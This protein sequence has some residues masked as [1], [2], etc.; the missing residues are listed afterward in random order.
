MEATKK[1]NTTVPAILTISS[2]I[3]AVGLYVYGHYYPQRLLEGGSL[4]FVFIWIM[5]GCSALVAIVSSYLLI[6]RGKG[7]RAARKY[8]YA[9]I[10]VFIILLAY[11]SYGFEQQAKLYSKIEVN[12]VTRQ[13]IM[14]VPA[15]YSPDRPMPL[16]IALHGGIGNA[17]QFMQE[18]GFNSLADQY[19]FIVVYP[20]G[21]GTFRYS[22][23]IWNSGTIEA[24]LQ[25]G[26][27]DVAFIEQLLAHIESTYAVN[28][29][30]IYIV[31]HS[32]GAMMS[33]RMAGE[34]ASAF[35]AVASVAGTIGGKPLPNASLYEIPTPS[36]PV[37][38]IE[39]H[40]LLDTNVRYN[41]GSPTSGLEV[42]ERWDISVNDTIG[43][44]V[45]YDHCNKTKTEVNSTNSLIS[46]DT[47]SGGLNSTQVKLFTFTTEGHFWQDLNKATEETYGISLSQ[48]I[49]SSLA[50]YSK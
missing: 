35:A 49:W 2:S 48:L 8:V 37:S 12:G 16:L 36:T 34:D 38:V 9:L 43:F 20:D 17:Y 22:D 46:E 44:W 33:Y 32:N 24:P 11:E 26:Y 23:H 42:G 40:G 47:Y 41:G 29:S 25:K 28:A 27:Q 50:K 19:G 15:N 10:V 45:T 5:V 3:V 14:H 4:F 13:Y 31:G 6:R 21:L 18:T 1:R 39:F 30:R 7:K